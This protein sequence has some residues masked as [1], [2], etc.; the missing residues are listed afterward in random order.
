MQRFHV[1]NITSAKNA[2]THQRRID[3][4]IAVGSVSPARSRAS[5]SSTPLAASP[6]PTA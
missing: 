5:R 2:Y 3:N 4:A 1:D 6:T